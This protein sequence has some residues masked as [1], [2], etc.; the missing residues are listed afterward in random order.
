MTPNRGNPDRTPEASTL[1]RSWIWTDPLSAPIYGS[2][3][4]YIN[5]NVMTHT[6]PFWVACAL[7]L[8]PHCNCSSSRFGVGGQLVFHFNGYN[9]VCRC[10][11]KGCSHPNRRSS[12]LAK[13]FQ[14]GDPGSIVH[15]HRGESSVSPPLYPPCPSLWS[16][17]Q[18]TWFRALYLRRLYGSTG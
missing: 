9:F 14:I 13:M 12:V 4:K 10:T 16:L 1:K 18:P 6:R 7:I 5:T 11:T 2:R 3:T 8:F 15:T 17:D